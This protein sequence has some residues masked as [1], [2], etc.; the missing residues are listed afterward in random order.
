MII[1]ICG[2]SGSGK[3]TLSRE[4]VNTHENAINLDIDKIGHQVI[5]ISE[6]KE[7]LV[8][9]FGRNLLNDKE[10]NRKKL[11]EIVFASRTK[12][13]KLSEITW[14]YMEHEIDDFIDKHHNNIIILD[15]LLLPK[16]KYFSMCDIKILMDIPYEIR[17]N[18]VIKRDN[19]TEKEFALRNQASIEFNRDDFDLVIKDNNKEKI[20]KLVKSI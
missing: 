15:W 1:G 3:S 4:I 19:I 20:R 10:I 18:R 5:M 11:A 13:D 7:D 16:T 9:Y 6:V 17:K 2:K 14:K 12:M 8:N